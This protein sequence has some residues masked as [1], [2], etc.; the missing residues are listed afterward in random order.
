MV[1]DCARTGD[2]DILA[3]GDCANVPSAHYGG[4]LRLESVPNALASART[5]V[6]TLLGQ[7][8][9]YAEVPW[10]WSDQYDLK[11]QM[12]G[13][14][15]GYD[16]TVVRGDPAQRKFM[17]L[18]LRAGELIAAESV[19]NPRDFMTVRQLI[20]QRARPDPAR[21]TDPEVALAI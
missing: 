17:V 18:Y 1:D 2:T 3:I 13:V 16:Q 15:S 7:H 19:N 21:L 6:A 8:R 4:R 9:P 20:A 11:L 14:R 12:A 10:F 5:A